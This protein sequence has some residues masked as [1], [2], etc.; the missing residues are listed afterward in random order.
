MD[1]LPIRRLQVRDDLIL[2]PAAGIW[3]V[4]NL[5]DLELLLL[6]GCNAVDPSY[7]LH[8]PNRKGEVIQLTTQTLAD[9]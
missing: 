3:E 8:L 2:D 7:C 6:I 4:L 1:L 5:D 9:K